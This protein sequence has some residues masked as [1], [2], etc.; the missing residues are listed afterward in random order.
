VLTNDLE[1]WATLTKEHPNATL[2]E[3]ILGAFCGQAANRLRYQ[4]QT[5]EALEQKIEQLERQIKQPEPF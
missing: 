3:Q 1:T 5:I 4:L 2:G